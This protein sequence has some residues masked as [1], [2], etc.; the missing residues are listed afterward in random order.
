M[1]QKQQSNKL[2]GLMTNTAFE[3]KKKM[4]SRLL[5]LLNKEAALCLG[6]AAE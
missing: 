2:D 6:T 4:D 3:A 1:M 5:H